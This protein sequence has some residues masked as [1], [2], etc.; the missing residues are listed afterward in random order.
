MQCSY[1]TPVALKVLV[2]VTSLKL[3]I[4]AYGTD[5]FTGRKYKIPNHLILPSLM[6]ISRA[7]QFAISEPDKLKNLNFSIDPSTKN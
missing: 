4:L 5:F 3:E 1:Q 2:K 7:K 6:N